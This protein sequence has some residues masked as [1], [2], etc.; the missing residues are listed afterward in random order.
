MSR[1][2]LEMPKAF[3]GR[4]PGKHLGIQDT[5]PRCHRDTWGEWLLLRGHRHTHSNR[6]SQNGLQHLPRIIDYP[7]CTPQRWN[8]SIPLDTV[9]PAMFT[10]SAIG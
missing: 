3:A 6:I 10:G 1:S 9:L 5:M 7:E 8:S 2:Q 4:R